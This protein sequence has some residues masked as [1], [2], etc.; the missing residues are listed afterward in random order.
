MKVSEG[1]FLTITLTLF[2]L[3]ILSVSTLLFP[4]FIVKNT[5]SSDLKTCNFADL[6]EEDKLSLPQLTKWILRF[7]EAKN[8]RMVAVLGF[9]ISA[10][11]IEIFIKS[12]KLAGI[13]HLF[14]LLCGV[15]IGWAVLASIF[16]P[17]MPLC[18]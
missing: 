12:R 8:A 14:I 10:L 7:S 5:D 1:R 11:I 15:A 6:W 3:L 4:T 18:L 17:F 2:S 9:L 13:F 16:L